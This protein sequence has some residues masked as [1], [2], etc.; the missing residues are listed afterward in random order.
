[1]S[2]LLTESTASNA[3][4]KGD[5]MH[6]EHKNGDVYISNEFDETVEFC[7]WEIPKLIN[8][9]RGIYLEMHGTKKRTIH[10]PEL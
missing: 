1:M 6:I 2:L 4:E 8:E 9:L 10:H 7:G 3:F 5:A